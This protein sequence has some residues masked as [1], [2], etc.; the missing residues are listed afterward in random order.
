MNFA[1]PKNDVA[2]KKIFGND[3]KKEILISFLNNILNFAGTD[4]EIVEITIANPYQAPKLED[5]KTTI[6]DIKA[7]D[8][9]GNHYIIEMQV[10]HTEAFEK[11]VLYYVS[12]AYAQ[13]LETGENYPTLNPVIFLGFL[14]FQLFKENPNYAS[15]HLI[16]EEK[17]N[18]H[19]FTDFELHF[20]ELP[21]F[22]KSLEELTEVKDKWIYFV[23]HAGD[24]SVIP[25]QMKEPKEIS[26][27][28]DAANKFT[29]TKDDLDAYDAKGIYI[30]DERQR[31]VHAHKEGHQEGHQEGLQEG[32]KEGEKKKAREIGKALLVRGIPIE[33]IMET[34]GLSKEDIQP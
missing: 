16:L 22:K 2:F 7:L 9:R 25:D 27:A 17:T 12:K 32:L 30:A 26:E 31:I 15:R 23:K 6:L 11:K 34:T 28:F 4:K 20:I 33:I 24:M 10:L 19:L 18:D 29:W 8:K 1:D 13:Q 21:K 14:N 3:N 5:L